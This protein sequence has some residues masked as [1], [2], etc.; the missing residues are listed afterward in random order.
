[1]V[2]AGTL[3]TNQMTVVALAYPTSSAGK[4]QEHEVT[5][6]S[7]V[8]K[9]EVVGLGSP[10]AVADLAKVCALF[11][12]TLPRICRTLCL[13]DLVISTGSTSHT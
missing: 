4:L 8:P 5:G 11:S 6:T 10:S 2:L 3:T 1:M 13:S 12:P 7:Y 9:G